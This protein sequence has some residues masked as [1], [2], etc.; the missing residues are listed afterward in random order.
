MLIDDLDSVPDFLTDGVRG[1]L[2]IHRNKDGEKAN[3]QRKAFTRI[4]NGTE[5]WKKIILELRELQL[6]QFPTHRIYASVNQRNTEKAIREFKRRQLQHDYDPLNI[7]HEFYYDIKNRFFS[8]LMSPMNKADYNLLID[9]DS[10][11][12]YRKA[13]CTLMPNEIL[14]DY[15]TKNGRHIISKPFNPTGC[16]L[17]IK[18]DDLLAIA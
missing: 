11:K 5:E 4:S 6:S 1:I 8:C 13:L 7:R 17:Q 10:N 18:K 15:A 14:F 2:L 9:C 12:E 3:A 16:T